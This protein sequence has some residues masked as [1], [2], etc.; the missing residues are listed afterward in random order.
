MRAWASVT[1]ANGANAMIRV[2]ING[3]GRIGRNVLRAYFDR[4][5]LASNLRIIAINDLG[6]P[7]INAHLLEF[8]TAHGRFSH[9]VTSGSDYLQVG[10]ERI[11]VLSE[12]SPEQLP[13]AELQID[14]VLECTGLFT[15]R[16]SASGHLTAGAQ[17]VLVSAP[18]KGADATIVYGVNHEQLRPEDRVISNASCTTKNF[19]RF[20]FNFR[21]HIIQLV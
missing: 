8:D 14:L 21:I 2:A 6:E 5:E 11:T 12:R 19:N 7:A 9:P 17:R 1:A 3:F 15:D 4:P 18:T 20:V 16:V 13:W 10:S